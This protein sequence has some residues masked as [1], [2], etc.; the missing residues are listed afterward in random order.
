MNNS[1]SNLEIIFCS[2]NN[3]NRLCV[4]IIAKLDDFFI[5]KQGVLCGL[6]MSS[7]ISFLPGWCLLLITYLVLVDMIL[8]FDIILQ[9]RKNLENTK[10]IHC[11]P[12]DP[13][14]A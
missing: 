2:C 1:S 6:L 5:I 11:Q 9:N 8:N 7:M 13:R 3:K 10:I 14:P 12:T 4:D